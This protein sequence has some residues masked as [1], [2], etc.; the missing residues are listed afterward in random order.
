MRLSGLE[1]FNVTIRDALHQRRR[2]HQRDRLE[3]V[4]ANDPERPVRRRARGRA[5]AG[6]KRRADHRRQHGRGDAR[7]KSGDGPLH[8]SDRVGTRHCARADHD[9]LVEVG[10]DRSGPEMRARQ[11]DRQLDLAEGRR[12]R[13]PSSREPDPPLWRRRGRDGLRRKRPGRHLRAQDRDLQALVQLPRQ[14]SRLSRPKTSSSIRTSSRSPPASKSTTTTP[15]T[16]STPRAGSR[17]TCRTQRSAAACRTCR[18]RSAATTRCAKRSTPCSSTTRSRRGHGHGHRQRRPARRLCRPRSRTARA[19]RRRRAE[20]P[21]RRHRSSAR[22]RRQVQDRCGK[23]GRK[24]RM[25]QPAG[26][27]A[28]GACAGARHHELHRRRHRGS[29]RQDRRCGRPPDQ[30]DRR[31]VDGRHEHRR[32]PVRS[33]QDVPAAGGQVGA[34]DEAGRRASDP[35]HRRRKEADGRSRRRRAREGQDRH[36]HRQGRRARH[37]QEHRLGGASVQ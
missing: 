29:A 22:N 18:S 25:A 9:R 4:R 1:P 27:E 24:P 10:S 11:G 28:S 12:R 6:R 7:F 33:G 17:R 3:G 36:R 21:R 37:R 31:P 13:V 15:S 8:E 5:P 23:K 30:R 20:P 26:R 35:V 19:R 32:R 34:R 14:R 16:S 2:T